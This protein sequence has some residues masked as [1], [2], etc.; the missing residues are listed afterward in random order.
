MF[1]MIFIAANSK[2]DFKKVLGKH[3]G[4]LSA[5][6]SNATNNCSFTLVLSTILTQ[7]PQFR[8]LSVSSRLSPMRPLK[9]L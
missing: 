7:M 8:V 3:F 6:T 1:S 4:N 2:N 5:S 9:H